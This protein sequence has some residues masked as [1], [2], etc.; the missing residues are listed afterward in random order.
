MEDHVDD[1]DNV[2][3]PVSIGTRECND[4]D[5]SRILSSLRVEEQAGNEKQEKKQIQQDEDTQGQQHQHQQ[6]KVHGKS[7][8]FRGFEY[9]TDLVDCW[10]RLEQ[11]E[12]WKELAIRPASVDDCHPDDVFLWGQHSD[13]DDDDDDDFV[14]D[15]RALQKQCTIVRKLLNDQ[16]TM[17]NIEQVWNDDELLPKTSTIPQAGFGL[18]YVPII[19]DDDDD[20][21]TKGSVII[22]KGTTICYYTGHIHTFN[23][24]RGLTD[25]SYLMMVM[26]SD[27]NNNKNNSNSHQQTSIIGDVFVD[28]LPMK[29]VKARYLNDPLNDEL[30]NCHYVAMPWRSAVVA[31]RD[32]QPNEELFA[33]YGDWYWAQQPAP[34]NRLHM[35][36]K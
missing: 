23:S 15:W 35:I 18:F 14:D 6:E 7:R 29:H 9:S 28:P 17:T 36:P 34:G 27:G 13:D 3:F 1:V 25:K 16:L 12:R 24:S 22:P 21:N 20:D 5:E 30:V 4:G 11:L 10:K 26:T 2:V 33:S 32:I 31:L 8:F 19:D